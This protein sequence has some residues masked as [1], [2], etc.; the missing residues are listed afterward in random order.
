MHNGLAA[1]LAKCALKVLAIV[2][3]EVV[4]GNW[5]PTILVYSL[6]DFV[7]SGVS[8]T[9]KEGEELGTEGS[10]GLVLEDDRVELGTVG[11]LGLV[12]HQAL[13]NRVDRVED[14]ELGDTGGT[15]AEKTS[16]VGLLLLAR[17]HGSH[18]EWGFGGC[19][20]GTTWKR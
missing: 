11:N 8:E 7:A 13:G 5:L 10:G 3:C 14:S 17:Y 4:A 16:D 6:R 19:R 18:C 15:R 20:R 1:L 9:G 2:C 12:A